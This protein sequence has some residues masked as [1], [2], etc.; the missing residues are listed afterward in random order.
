MSSQEDE[1]TDPYLKAI[2][3]QNFMAFED[4]GWIELRPITLLFG[5]NSSGKSAIIRAMRLL[6]QSL[7]T[8]PDE[9][10]LRLVSEHGVDVGGFRDVIFQ[11]A[12]TNVMTFGLRCDI[13]DNWEAIQRAISPHSEKSRSEADKT[14]AD[15]LLSF[16][17]NQDAGNR[18]ELVGIQISLPADPQEGIIEQTLFKAE[19]SDREAP[20]PANPFSPEEAEARGDPRAQALGSDNDAEPWKS[21]PACLTSQDETESV[22]RALTIERGFLP[23]LEFVS[24]TAL[25]AI[26]PSAELVKTLLIAFKEKIEIF[27]QTMNWV[28]PLRPI[29]QRTYYLN[30]LI[31]EE[32]EQQGLSAML[33]FIEGGDEPRYT[34]VG[35]WLE[36]LGLGNELLL[37]RPAELGGDKLSQLMLREDVGELNLADVGFGASQVIPILLQS[38]FADHGQLVVIEQP[39]LHLHPSAQAELASLFVDVAERG[40]ARFLIET[41]SEVLLLRTMRHVAEAESRPLDDIGKSDFNTTSSLAILQFCRREQG[42]SEV[43]HVHFNDN[44]DLEEIPMGF[45]DFF[46]DDMK[47]TVAK[48]KAARRNRGG[49]Q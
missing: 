33:K 34:E 47:E 15:L 2:R 30:P 42:K 3:L 38:L 24:Q 20:D 13:S 40:K 11:G 46:M 27:L 37:P 43:A 25:S 7:D 21:Y 31:G 18:V 9:G 14:V 39:E 16:A 10:N 23:L 32:W 19:R 48:I 4:T 49:Q 5:K 17:S 6:K 26:S 44:G 1:R 29:P 41:H 28:A 8:R 35:N 12:A 45:S 22:E 36:R